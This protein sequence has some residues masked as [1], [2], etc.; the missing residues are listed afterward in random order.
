[1]ASPANPAGAI[2]SDSRITSAKIQVNSDATVVHDLITE[3]LV[4]SAAPAGH[5]K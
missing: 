5:E 2:R 1:M 4:V 3:L